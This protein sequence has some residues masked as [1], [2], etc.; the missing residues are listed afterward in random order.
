[1]DL[2]ELNIAHFDYEVASTV[3]DFIP[4]I[5]EIVLHDTIVLAS[6]VYWYAISSQMK[7]FFDRWSEL[8]NFRKDLALK[9]ERKR[10][11][12]ICSFATDFPLGCASFENPIRQACNYM[13]ID[14]GG[15]YYS[16]P[17]ESYVRSFGFP[18]LE[19]FRAKI[20]S[21]DANLE[22]KIPSPRLSLRLAMM[23]DRE[24]IYQWK[25]HSDISFETEQKSFKDFKES[26]KPY[27]FQRPLTSRGH[28]F[29]ME[30]DSLA[31][32]AL[33]FHRP[34]AKN[35]SEV[36]LWLSAKKYCEPVR[37]YSREHQWC[38]SR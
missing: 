20:L 32:G 24:D 9:L 17:D 19:E 13:N 27:Y 11:F 12:M 7:V 38:E 2:K 28:V 26:W 37:Q 36:E 10:L 30:Q 29:I 3:D 31:I 4:L 35:R 6:P 15:C 21:K 1:M 25:Y 16:Y 18:D 34:D 14:Y 8:L 23:S 33:V 5:E 22:L